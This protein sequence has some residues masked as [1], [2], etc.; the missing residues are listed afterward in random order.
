M[1][2]NLLCP[3]D[4]R[5]Q[6]FLDA[7]LKD[8]CPKGAAR[9]PANTFVLDR[10]GIGARDVAAACAAIL[11]FALPEFLPRAAGHPAQSQER[12]AH[13]A[14]NLPYRRRRFAGSRRQAGGAEARLRCA[15]GCSA[16]ASADDLLDAAVHR[17][18]G[19][20][21]CDSLSFRCCCGRWFAR[22]RSAIR[23]R[24]WRSASSRRAVWS[25]ISISWRAFSATRG[26]P[27]L[28]ENDAALDVMHWTGHTGC[29]ILAPHLVRDQEEGSGTAA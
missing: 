20:S 24:R 17:R 7:Y 9:L 16:S 28:P 15:A 10:A 11:F 27:Y 1:L 13:H 21:R 18:S 6:E 19:R 14:G 12:P 23:R 22:R 2:G 8:M 4:Q 5:I 26:D 25:A 3:A 29:V